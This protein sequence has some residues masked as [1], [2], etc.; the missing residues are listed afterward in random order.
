[1]QPRDQADHIAILSLMMV[2]LLARRMKDLG[3][4]D[5]DT[6]NHLHR[7]VKTVRAHARASGIDDL[8]VLFDNID[9]SLS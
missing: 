3:H 1:M 4:L 9:K 7:L 2:G 8:N 6:S 5:Q